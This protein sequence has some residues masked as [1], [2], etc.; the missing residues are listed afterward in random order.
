MGS[1]RLS[2]SLFALT[3]AFLEQAG[4]DE[5]VHGVALQRG[6]AQRPAEQDHP[7]L[8]EYLHGVEHRVVVSLLDPSLCLRIDERRR[9]NDDDDDDE[10]LRRYLSV[11]SLS[12]RPA[13]QTSAS[14]RAKPTPPPLSLDL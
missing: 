11:L 7:S 1:G 8:G 13:K 10:V 2:P 5:G 3:G 6:E 9:T 14:L 4:A 12:R